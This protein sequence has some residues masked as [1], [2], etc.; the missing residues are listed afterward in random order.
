MAQEPKQL[1]LLEGAEHRLE[2]R[3]DELEALLRDWIPT[4]LAAAE[5]TL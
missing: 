4:T 2:E 1:V 5:A 3:R